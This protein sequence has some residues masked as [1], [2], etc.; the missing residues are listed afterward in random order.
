MTAPMRCRI[1][2]LVSAVAAGL[3]L[4]AAPRAEAQIPP[5][6]T[7]TLEILSNRY[8][9]IRNTRANLFFDISRLIGD[10]LTDLDNGLNVTRLST[11]PTGAG[12]PVNVTFLIQS[13]DFAANP[14][15]YTSTTFGSGG[16]ITIQPTRA[17]DD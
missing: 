12:Q 6:S 14:S 13:R 3:A 11:G 5:P 4:L 1:W 10:P 7:T 8:L 16:G 17:L 9:T 15:G 2:P